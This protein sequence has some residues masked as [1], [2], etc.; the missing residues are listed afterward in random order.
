MLHRVSSSLFAALA[1]VFVSSVPADAAIDLGGGSRILNADDVLAICETNTDGQLVLDLPGAKPWVLDLDPRVE[2]DTSELHPISEFA[3]E[4]AWRQ[5]DPRFTATVP[6][7]IVVLPAPR[8]GLPLSSAEDGTIFLSPGSAPYT[9][10]QVAFLVA[11]EF[12]HCVHRAHMDPDPARWE[13]YKRL[14]SIDDESTFHNWADHASRPR[15]IFAEDFRFLF[16]GSDANYSGGIE[17]DDLALPSRVG[18]LHAMIAR[19]VDPTAATVVPVPRLRVFP[20]PTRGSVTVELASGVGGR[21]RAISIV[22]VNGRLVRAL[23]RDLALPTHATSFV[24]DGRTIRGQ[25]APS[26]IYY[27]LVEGADRAEPR[28]GRVVLIR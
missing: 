19:L 24:W 17:N 13:A 25:D 22:D 28:S 21:P 27:A 7:T 9:S 4:A 8:V 11:H 3:A 23:D 2:D 10:R 15:E 14:R 18:G 6:V 1:A 12:G 20:N 16:G 26:G 5:I